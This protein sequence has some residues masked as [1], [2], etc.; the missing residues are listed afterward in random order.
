VVTHSPP[1][2][3]IVIVVWILLQVSVAVLLVAALQTSKYE[4]DEG[5]YIEA[6]LDPLDEKGERGRNGEGKRERGSCGP[7]DEQ[8]GGGI[9]SNRHEM[10]S[11]TI[12]SLPSL[13]PFLPS[14][15]DPPNLFPNYAISSTARPLFLPSLPLSRQSKLGNERGEGGGGEG[16]RAPLPHCSLLLP[17]T[18]NHGKITAAR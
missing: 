2:S 6:S 3:Y 12:P 5:I 17:A 11:R 1:C 18:A 16:G 9:R 14:S 8:R 15:Q 10:P 13:R 7:S 4:R